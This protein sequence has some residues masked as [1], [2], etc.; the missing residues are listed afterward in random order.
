M[1]TS[2]GVTSCFLYIGCQIAVLYY[3]R[4]SG[5]LGIYQNYSSFHQGV[6][7]RAQSKPTTLTRTLASAAWTAK[8][9]K[10]SNA[11]ASKNSSV[12]LFKTIKADWVHEYEKR[13]GQIK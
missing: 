4:Y 12:A 13:V 1:V 5:S 11:Y 7:K 2:H 6:C 9:T 3:V 10:G 8:T